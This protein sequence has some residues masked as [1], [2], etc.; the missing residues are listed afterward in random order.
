[1]CGSIG[2]TGGAGD[3]KSVGGSIGFNSGNGLS[4]LASTLSAFARQQ[5]EAAN[6][7][8]QIE[9]GKRRYDEEQ[10]RRVADAIFT[11]QEAGMA[12]QQANEQATQS[13]MEIAREMLRA[14]EE[15]RAAASAAGIAG[16]VVNRMVTDISVTE[17]QK[18]AVVDSNRDAIVTTQQIQKHKAKQSTKMDPFYYTKPGSGFNSMLGIVPGLFSGFNFDF[19]WASCGSKGTKTK[20]GQ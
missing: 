14:K 7:K 5:Q 18:R 15:S 12:Q 2:Y 3:G 10:R 19:S 17:Q 11:M 4:M 13:K 6:A 1:M 20:C 8:A 16:N 9:I